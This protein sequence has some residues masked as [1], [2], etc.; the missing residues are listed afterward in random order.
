MSISRS[1]A[2][3]RCVNVA[4]PAKLREMLIYFASRGGINRAGMGESLVYQPADADLGGDMPEKCP[5]CGSEIVR[6]P[7]EADHRC[8]NVACPAKLREMLIYFASRGVMNIEGMGESLVNQLADTDL[9][10][11]ISDIYKL[12]KDKLLTL[13]RMGEKS[14]QNVLDGIE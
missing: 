3:H 8:V 1:L 13:E 4:C 2:D 7:G 12:T 9:V 14:A 11:D 5:S 6:P 10:G